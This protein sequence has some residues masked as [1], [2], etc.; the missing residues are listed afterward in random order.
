MTKHEATQQGRRLLRRMEG[1]G[2]KLR[3][4]E[5]IGWHYEVQNGGIEIYVSTVFRTPR[6]SVLLH[7][8]DTPGGG[9]IFWYT[10]RDFHDPNLAVM[11][12]LLHAQKFVTM[13]QGGLDALKARLAKKARKR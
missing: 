3:V 11:A 8:G 6:Y 5:N 7:E 1:T 10:N 4:W 12:Q 9:S 13:L 2:W